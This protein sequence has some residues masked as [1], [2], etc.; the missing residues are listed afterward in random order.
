[1]FCHFPYT[2]YAHILL[3]IPR[4]FIFIG[5]VVNGIVFIILVFPCSLLVYRS[6]IDYFV[7]ILYPVN[8]LNSLTSSGSFL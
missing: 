8:L 3:C 7:L 2:D 5:A 6:K 1:M 4:C